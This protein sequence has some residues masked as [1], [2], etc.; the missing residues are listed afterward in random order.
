MIRVSAMLTILFSF[1]LVG[2]G[3]SVTDTASAS[4]ANAADRLFTNAAVYTV[5]E[6]R[7]WA[8]A[9]AVTDGKI[10]FVGDAQ[11]AK[12]F[13]G[14]VTEIVDLDGGMLLPG[15]HDSHV[16][17][18]VGVSTDEECDLLSLES[19]EEID[20]KLA[21]CVELQGFGDE[22]W[23]VGGGWG[24]WL[25]PEIGPSK[26]ILDALFPDRPVYLSSSYGH[27]AWV[28]SKALSIADIDKDTPDPT[29]GIITRNPESGEPNGA[30][31]ESA[32][33]LVKNILPT[34]PMAHELKSLRAA[35]TLAHSVGITA[36]IEGGLDDAEMEPLVE[37]ADRGELD[38][39]T[40]ISVSP[41]GYDVATFDD[42]I[43]E[44]L[45]MREQWRRP[46]L[47]VDSVKVFMDGVV[48]YCTSPLLEDYD[49]PKCGDG[50]DY[51]YYELEQLGKL[52]TRFDSMGIK[53]H[54]HAIGDAAVRRAL[55]GFDVMR[56]ENGPSDVRHHIVHL[57]LVHPDDQ[58]RL[59]ELDIGANFQ[60]LWAYPELPDGGLTTVLLGEERVAAS[61]P[62]ASVR[63]HGARIVGGSDYFV[64]DIN[65][66]LA[67]ETGITRQD[68][69]TN[70]GG[71]LNAD[72]SLN[73][74]TMIDAYTINGAY[75]MG[76]DGEQGSIEVGKRADFVVLD[77][78]L[79]D[80]PA[81]EI[82]EAYAVMTVFGG[83]TVY[84]KEGQ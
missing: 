69:W 8:E 64:T 13:V 14:E 73:L 60:L 50:S 82:S 84:T 79:F 53:I 24:E 59:A 54:V 28:N 45:E 21:A 30:L 66:L 39:R 65:P 62:A 56:N 10:V 27:A 2:C 74:A 23:I 77:R 41:Y 61:Y 29:G 51:F 63:D 68:P 80:I 46:N 15:F 40:V 26:E 6:Q 7:S 31:L 57:Q 32:V 49:D 33:K 19:V 16:H 38:L 81:T 3:D 36:V 11:A 1:M 42:S 70:D 55:D 20:E 48:E 67:I 4:G 78:N 83:R 72:E 9:V 25:Y 71:V 37:F 52:F 43:F 44:F 17:L 47:D 22:R 5:D 34:P 18:L 35:Q 12:A 58:P 75:Q 76:L